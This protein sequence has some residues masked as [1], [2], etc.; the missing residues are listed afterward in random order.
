MA[1]GWKFRGDCT[2][3]VVKTKA[4]I[5]CVVT[6]QLICTFVFA[7]SHES[8][9][10]DFSSQRHFMK[11]ETKSSTDFHQIL[12][13]FVPL[14]VLKNSF[15]KS[16]TTNAV[17]VMNIKRNLT[18]SLVRSVR[19]IRITCPCI[20]YPRTPHFNIVKLGFTG[21]YIIFLFLL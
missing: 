7:F 6:R 9:N 12:N 3:Y 16:K 2:I 11:K 21:V 20:L 13:I 10:F 8:A 17:T 1:R 15:E 14:N 19:A 18:N 5:S 4:L